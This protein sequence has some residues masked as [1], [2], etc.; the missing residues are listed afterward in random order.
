MKASRLLVAVILAAALGGCTAS[1]GAT[2]AGHAI[3]APAGFKLERPEPDFACFAPISSQNTLGVS[4]CAR[5]LV[6]KGVLAENTFAI[7]SYQFLDHTVEVRGLASDG[8]R[9]ADSVYFI[10]ETDDL[11]LF[12]ECAGDQRGRA[13]LDQCLPQRA[14]FNDWIRS[15]LGV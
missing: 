15:V 8:S 1:R 9:E 10:L 13:L 12:G 6:R 7:E 14:S 11:L 2:V 5:P 3:P 4:F